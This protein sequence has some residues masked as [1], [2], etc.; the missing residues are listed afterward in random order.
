MTSSIARTRPA[1]ERLAARVTDDV[2][3]AC[4]RGWPAQPILVDVTPDTGPDLAYTTNTAPP[5]FAGLATLNPSVAGGSPAA[6]ECVFHEAAHVIDATFARW[7]EE[8]SA[9]QGVAPPPELW[10]ALLF[11]TAGE[12]T[13]RALGEAGT[14]R[15]DLAQGFAADL[16]ALDE[17][18]LPYLDGRESLAVAL[19]EVV[20]GADGERKRRA[21]SAP[22][23]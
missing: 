7:V 21:A 17:H 12:L 19:R 14:F 8:E 5:G 3:A 9:R 16:P 6:I 18:W 11:Y 13:R 22:A 1:V 4:A 2:A 23:R 20:R 10:H 15:A